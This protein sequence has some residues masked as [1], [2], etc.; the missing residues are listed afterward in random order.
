M[1]ISS[2]ADVYLNR[3]G[4]IALKIFKPSVDFNIAK[5]FT[6]VADIIQGSFRAYPELDLTMNAITVKSRYSY[7][8][9]TFLSVDSVEDNDSI[10]N[11]G[12]R[13]NKVFE[14]SFLRDPL[15]AKTLAVRYLMRYSYPPQLFA[16][17]VKLQGL[18][19]DLGDIVEVKHM[20]APAGCGKDMDRIGEVVELEFDA[21]RMRVNVLVQDIESWL[22][23][24]FFLADEEEVPANWDDATEEQRAKW[25]YL[26]DET[27]GT[28]PDGSPGKRLW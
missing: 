11:L 20:F 22:A 13:Y 16:F 18:N 12:K 8:W 24:L 21:D 4:K 3:D 7:V 10:V 6:D 25:G 1:L 23:N 15:L 27:K 9:E 26:C 28:F 2:F 14:F 17:A 19:V 5:R